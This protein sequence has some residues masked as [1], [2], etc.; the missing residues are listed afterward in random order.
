MF[1]KA[2]WV[3]EPP[4][5]TFPLKF[6]PHRNIKY[7]PSC[8]SICGFIFVWILFD[9]VCGVHFNSN[10]EQC[11]Y[12]CEFDELAEVVHPKPWNFMS[13]L[14]NMHTTSYINETL[15]RVFMIY[16]VCRWSCFNWMREWR[17]ASVHAKIVNGNVYNSK[18]AHYTDM[19]WGFSHIMLHFEGDV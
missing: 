18:A 8:Q 16:C 10:F 14:T 17:A 1:N 11:F 4:S 9:T 3:N 13:M 5:S 6:L 12:L 15:C 7:N 2:K 19:L